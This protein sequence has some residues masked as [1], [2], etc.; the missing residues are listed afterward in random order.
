[1]QLIT[2]TRSQ[3]YSTSN[4]PFADFFFFSFP[5]FDGADCVSSTSRDWYAESPI[6]HSLINPLLSST[7]KEAK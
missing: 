7:H 2:L 5:V 6:I 4:L 1:M 3:T